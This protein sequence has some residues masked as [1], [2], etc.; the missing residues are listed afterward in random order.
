M[1]TGGLL[2]TPSIR[3]TTGFLQVPSR[4]FRAYSVRKNSSCFSSAPFA[5][6]IATTSPPAQNTGLPP[7]GAPAITITRHASDCSQTFPVSQ[8]S[9]RAHTLMAAVMPSAI[10]MLRVFR[11]AG[12]FSSITRS[13][14]TDT[15]LSASVSMVGSPVMCV[16]N[17]CMGQ[18]G[19]GTK[20]RTIA[21]VLQERKRATR[22]S[23]LLIN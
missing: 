7:L 17:G 19:L 4:W 2:V 14:P 15:S 20:G 16:L 10:S 5:F 6:A 13:C 11:I 1:R 3:A 23:R 21:S 18:D 9:T 22:P 8:R 12:R